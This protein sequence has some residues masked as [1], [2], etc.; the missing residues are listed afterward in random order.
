ML[1]RPERGATDD[2]VLI[3]NGGRDP[4]FGARGSTSCWRAG[5]RRP[6]SPRSAS[7]SP[8]WATAPARRARSAVFSH[9]FTDRV[10]DTRAAI[11]AMAALGFNRFAMHGLCVGAYHALYGALADPRLS[12]LMLINL[13]LFTV[14]TSNAL[15]EIEQ[16]GQ[17]AGF[18]P[19]QDAAT[20]RLGQPA[21]RPLRLADAEARGA[22]PS[23]PATPSAGCTG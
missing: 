21:G 3:P 2:M 5:W 13:P 7:I 1:C 11:D 20:E 18:L 6:A 19:R 9:A 15:G 14:P 17:S 4:S 12:R 10:A 16:R 8:G 23:A 22:V